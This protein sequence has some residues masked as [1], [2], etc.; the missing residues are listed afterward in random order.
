MNDVTDLDRVR[1]AVALQDWMR[2]CRER[3][4]SRYPDI[5]FDADRWPIQSKYGARTQ[6]ISLE[7]TLKDFSR[8]E[9]TYAQAV[10]CMAAELA[11]ADENKTV[12]NAL[13]AWRLLARAGPANLLDLQRSHL[14]ALERLVL[15][16]CQ[17]H[18][19]SAIKGTNRLADLGRFIDR[20]SRRGV[21][22]PAMWRVE[23]HVRRAL[24]MLV[25][26]RRGDF[27]E[28]KATIL[29]RQIEALSDA[30]SAMFMD[31]P[32]L[33]DFD[34]SA[35][36]TLGVMMCAPSR[37]N[38][39]L[40][41]A[42]DDIV[43][44][45]DYAKRPDGRDEDALHRVHQLLLHKGSKGADWG[46]KPV[47]NF[48]VELL[49][50]CMKI[51]QENGQRSRMLAAWYE[52]HPTKLYLP[53]ALEKLRGKMIDRSAL[54]QIINLSESPPT[55]KRVS[56][57]RPIWE[58]VHA[59]GKL[60]SISN[61]RALSTER[62][63]RK[64]A[65]STIQA[66]AW[67]DIE[68]ILLRRVE[69]ALCAVR[70]VTQLNNYVGRLTNM[71]MLF[72]F[73]ETPFLPRSIKYQALRRRFKQAEGERERYRKAKGKDME[74]TIFEKL[75]L[76][77]VVDAKVE[78]AWIDT[79]D[80]RRWLT[81]QAMNARE[82]LS[83]V[84]INK[85][86]NRLSIDQL[87]HYDFRSP[88]QKADQ[89]AMPQ[90]Q[91]LSDISAALE[92]IQGIESEYG[93]RTEIVTAHDVGVSVTSMQA[94]ALATD[95]RPVART[96]NQIIIVYPSRF[97]ACLHQHHETPCRAYSSCLP[98]GEN[99][100]VKGHLPTND[101]V[102]KRHE[103]LTRSIVNQLDRLVTAHNRQIADCPEGL[104]AHMLA[105]VRKG[106]TAEQMADELIDQFH[107]LKDRIKSPCLRN[108][109]EEAFVA[110]GMVQQLDDPDV[111][112]G[113][114][115][116]YHNPA[117]HASPGHERA[118]DA[119]GG[120]STIDARLEQFER[121][122]PRFAP[123]RLGLKDERELMEQEEDDDDE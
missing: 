29:D 39:P 9:A 41:M 21:I 67:K 3:V 94:I 58:E 97:G 49:R 64:R 103:L 65:R 106:M 90:V 46:A 11:L 19:V 18:A 51:L 31:D 82:R 117:R 43:T 75:G 89:V 25:R 122:H 111:S 57:V 73:E 78:Y 80:P 87:A 118:L 53:P 63:G 105:L 84:L 1:R 108:R 95:N 50:L 6:D 14:R 66:V 109:L 60:Q 8:L 92:K 47:L 79:H 32:R 7:P 38:E 115:M 113:A 59:A 72:D 121:E 98:C 16:D 62:D 45:E 61:P 12:G 88:T 104:E 110:R 42:V 74:P 96:S 107:E 20:L 2:E 15:Q 76:T 54:W 116:R 23:F 40:C 77:M 120:R 56:S 86:A 27:R 33:S 91:E 112:S 55:G 100:V 85:W 44:V 70:R 37:V 13:S 26:E 10:R 34:R 71:L 52:R 35:L 114:L 36:A 99:L 48:M 83:D 93:L 17:N 22:E 81:T 5:D 30:M 101:E 68:V 123:T 102:R 69:S 4:N 28:F 24:S 119:H